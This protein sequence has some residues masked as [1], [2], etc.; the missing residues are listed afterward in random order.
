MLVHG[1]NIKKEFIRKKTDTNVFTAVRETDI[2]LEP[3]KL[4][5]IT[6]RSGSGKST[7]LN[8]LSGILMPDS[9]TV[10]YDDINIYEMSDRDLSRFRNRNTGYIPQGSSAVSS[11]NVRENILLPAMFGG[12]D[13]RIDDRE[14]D[15]MMEKLSVYELAGVMPDELS[16]GELRRMAVA[17][18][19]ILKPAVIYAD[20]PTGDLDD[21]N[22]K[23]VFSMLREAA[24]AG[25]CVLLVTH[26][27]DAAGYADVMYRMDAGRLDKC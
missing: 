23:I 20:E 9:G 7:L 2:S 27:S 4:T 11:L 22:T 10:C 24:D 15:A 5:V 16:G 21:E 19:L 8:M 6:G 26:E 18:A 12:N 17:R 13:I 1:K 14:L 25:A 3:G